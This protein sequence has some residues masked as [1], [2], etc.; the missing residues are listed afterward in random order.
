MAST[1]VGVV[2]DAVRKAGPA[3]D[4]IAVPDL[5]PHELMHFWYLALAVNLQRPSTWPSVTT[6]QAFTKW[7]EASGAGKALAHLH[8]MTTELLPYV[9]GICDAVGFTPTNKD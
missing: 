7:C 9:E 3:L 4:T 6:S 8:T 2:T 1:I 5:E